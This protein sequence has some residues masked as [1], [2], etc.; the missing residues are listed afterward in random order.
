MEFQSAGEQKG[1][2]LRKDFHKFLSGGGEGGGAVK[3]VQKGYTLNLLRFR[4]PDKNLNFFGV[5]RLRSKNFIYLT[6]VHMYM[7]NCW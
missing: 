6:Y 4:K 1:G 3:G 2:N 5:N 7:Y